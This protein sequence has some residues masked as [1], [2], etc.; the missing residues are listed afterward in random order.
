[1]STLTGVMLIHGRALS[2]QDIGLIRQ[3]LDR[4]ADFAFVDHQPLAGE[5]YYYVRVQQVDEQMAWSSP[6]WIRR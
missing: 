3:A 4:E 6:T 5:S 1:M 2:A